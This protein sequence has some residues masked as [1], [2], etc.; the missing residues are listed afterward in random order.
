MAL[1]SS[2]NL[3]AFMM[4]NH[5]IQALREVTESTTIVTTAFAFLLTPSIPFS[6][7]CPYP[8]MAHY[9]KP[10]SSQ[11]ALQMK[12]AVA[13]ANSLSN[14]AQ[15]ILCMLS[16]QKLFMLGGNLSWAVDPLYP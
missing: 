1:N 11:T 5:C 9:L 10:C 8:E 13:L 3:E 2:P 12:I 7:F 16:V 6:Y 4:R 15:N 14:A